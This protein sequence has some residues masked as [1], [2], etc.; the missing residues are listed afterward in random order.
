MLAPNVATMSH[1]GWLRAEAPHRPVL[2]INPMSGGGKA[3]RA[4]L[5]E[6]ARERGIEPVV[7]APGDDL[8]AIARRAI[9]GGAGA[10]GMAGGDGSLAVVASLALASGLPFVCI[11]TGTRNHFARDLGVPP[12]DL[13]GALDAFAHA[14][15][16][17]IDV[18]EVNGRLFLNNVS[19]GIYGA[20]VQRA[21]YRN[22]K[23]RT[24]FET[25]AEV[26]GPSAQLPAVD[27]VDDLGIDHADPAVV[28][29]SNN[30]YALEGPPAPG[31][32]PTLDSGL[33]GILVLHKPGDPRHGPG[34]GWTAPSLQVAAAQP[35][36]AGVDGEALRLNPP[37]HFTIR[38]RA[39]R[40]RIPTQA[41]AERPSVRP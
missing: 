6:A 36:A 41:S 29:V 31:I 27:V 35:V 8:E 18:G 32:R 13:V 33:L 3:S 30:P 14:L 24:L 37:L 10:L 21:S 38:P 16:G 4:G 40:V 15:E 2:V 17:A 11:P 9:S 1:A 19:L 7:L 25:A 28:L 12:D 22:A 26:L 39:L 34:R 20:A 23:L 5:E